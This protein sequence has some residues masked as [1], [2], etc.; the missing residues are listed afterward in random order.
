MSGLLKFP[1]FE[2]LGLKHR[3]IVE[4]QLRKMQPIASELNYTE[5]FAWR[6]TRNTKICIHN[7]II[8]LDFEK[9]G[10]HYIVFLC[11]GCEIVPVAREI[12]ENHGK[13]G[14]SAA[15]ACLTENAAAH[16]K[17]ESDFEITSDRAGSDYVYLASDLINLEGR[18][19]DGKRNL[20][21]QFRSNYSYELVE[22][23]KKNIPEAA[24]IQAEWCRTRQCEPGSVLSDENVAIEQMLANFTELEIFGAML[25]AGGKPAAFT[26]AGTL[27]AKTSVTYIEKGLQGYKGIYQAIN[28]MFAEKYLSKYEFINR[29]QDV[30]D[31]GL[32]HAKMSYHP[33][34]MVHKYSVKLK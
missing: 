10:M 23:T 33:H 3:D 30:G 17:K 1:E 2:L 13:N 29:E 4:A 11:A 21:K 12:L 22:M 6:P 32:R 5:I 26:L 7:G 18:K 34:H 28:Q 20:I 8:T 14:F 9:K 25:K 16:F 31:D 24:E 15:I 19:Y 27:N